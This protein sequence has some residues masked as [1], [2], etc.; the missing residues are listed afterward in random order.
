LIIKIEDRKLGVLILSSAND[1]GTK[2]KSVVM[3][4]MVLIA[5]QMLVVNGG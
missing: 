3:Q 5:A 2:T 4:S 1:T